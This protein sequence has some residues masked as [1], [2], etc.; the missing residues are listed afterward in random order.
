MLDGIFCLFEELFVAALV[1]VVADV[2]LEG[3]LNL[4]TV[5][6]VA[7]DGD[8]VVVIT[9]LLNLHGTTL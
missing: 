6:V 7:I 9:G 4:I 1:V 8:K 5:V 3:T 2:G